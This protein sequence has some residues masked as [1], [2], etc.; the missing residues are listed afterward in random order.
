MTPLRAP[1]SNPSRPPLSRFH[2]T[3]SNSWDGL[4]AS[5]PSR[6]PSSIGTAPSRLQNHR[7]SLDIER[8]R[9]T[10][11]IRTR[12][13]STSVI[14]NS[15]TAASQM[16]HAGSVP[17]PRNMT[18]W[19][20]PRTA[21]AFAAAGLLDFDKDPPGSA[22]RPPSRFATS[23]S[24]T[25][26][27]SRS[28]YTPSRMAY[29]EAGSTSSYGARSGSVSRAAGY[30]E[31]VAGPMGETSPRTVF[32]S[33][34][35]ALT[36][37]SA[38]SLHSEIQQLQDKHALETSALL[39]ALADSQRTTRVLR[40]ENGQLRE[41]IQILEDKLA[42]AQERIQAILYSQPPAIPPNPMYSKRYASPG[43]SERRAFPSHSRKNSF[44]RARG[45][46]SSY[47][48]L[49][50]SPD[51]PP[52]VNLEPAFDATDAF[53]PPPRKRASGA[54]SVF[55][56]LP[57]N[58]SM[59]MQE[60]GVSPDNFAAFSQGSSSPPGSPTM[61]LARVHAGSSPS[62][63]S[64]IPKPSSRRSFS[65]MANKSASSA[66]NI[67]PTTASFSIMTSSPGSL[68]LRPE[69]ERHLGDMPP[70]DLDA[71]D[72]DFDDS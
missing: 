44:L 19:L 66:G 11:S 60:E 16:H 35:T 7:P 33:A 5:P 50:S 31:G 59:I 46:P 10:G 25:D 20:G 26:R 42:D 9:L 12:K 27:D 64:S 65:H 32:S 14:E 24:S 6:A 34:S 28:R 71:E 8:P 49:R 72:F 48:D 1:S 70:L 55:A 4:S 51:A 67:S 53:K 62:T 13:R 40:D 21:K 56:T 36:S 18:D 30:S 39:N 52:A 63:Y 45:E 38:S 22:S 29:S 15:V 68:N 23:R 41:R 61:V 37:V 69:H 54:S 47:P 43:S 57:S 17:S 58:M 3:P 2:A